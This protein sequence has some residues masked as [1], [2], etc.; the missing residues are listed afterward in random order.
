S[1]LKKA[2][3]LAGDN[4]PAASLNCVVDRKLS[5]ARGPLLCLLLDQMH[6]Q[7]S[8]TAVELVELIFLRHLLQLFH[9]TEVSQ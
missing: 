2:I 1:V 6:Q 5:R 9:R 8:P 4:L 7:H 3:S